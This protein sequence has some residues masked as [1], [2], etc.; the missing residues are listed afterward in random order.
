MYLVVRMKG[1]ILLNYSENLNQVEE[2]EK[3]RFLYDILDQMG[4]PITEFWSPGETLNVNQKIKLRNTLT[5]FDVH[6]LDDREGRL[7][8]YVE[9]E[10]IGTWDKCNYKL[11]KDMSAL[12]PRK[13]LYF[14]MEVNCWSI[15]ED[16]PSSEDESA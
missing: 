13:R 2:E 14:E 9:N 6:I 3:N 11:K 7:E 5:A 1:T 4:V 15:F 8:V 10:L 16:T 12:D